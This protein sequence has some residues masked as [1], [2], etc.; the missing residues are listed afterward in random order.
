MARIDLPAVS[1]HFLKPASVAYP[2]KD[3]AKEVVLPRSRSLAFLSDNRTAE[4]AAAN[5]LRGDSS[6]C[7]QSP[8][9]F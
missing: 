6:P 1:I 7:V 4:A 9:D 8:V 2:S 5:R 3:G